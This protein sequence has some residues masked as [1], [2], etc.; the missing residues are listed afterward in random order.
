M[1]DRFIGIELRSLNNA[2]RRY[3]ETHT[4]PLSD[5]KITCTNAWIIGF[6]DR[7]ESDVYQ[8]DL[9]YEFG[10][11]RSTASKV[12]ILLEKKGLIER[13]GVS[14][15]ARL[16]KLVLTKKARQIADRMKANGARM[17]SRLTEGFTEQELATLAE[18]M[19]RMREN[20]SS[21]D[22]DTD[23]IEREKQI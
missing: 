8:R 18:Y 12:L 4:A 5:D 22:S 3:L 14:H 15:D 7:S 9:E 6:I 11:T 21:A 17:E 19:Q 10:I 1:V 13:V 20:L 16:K 23:T 2:V